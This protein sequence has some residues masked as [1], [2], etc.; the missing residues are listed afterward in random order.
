MDLPKLRYVAGVSWPRSGHH[1]L[2]ELLGRYFGSR[3][4]YC[5]FHQAED[6]CKEVPCVRRDRITLS[7]NHDLDLLTPIAPDVPYL[8][9][10]RDFLPSVVS[11]Y[12]LFKNWR[13][14]DSP[15]AFEH[16]AKWQT[17]R[18]VK[19]YVKWISAW[20][21]CRNKLVVKYENLM[22]KPAWT[23]ASVAEF[24]S[25]GEAVDRNR[26]WEICRTANKQEATENGARV[27][28]AF[29]VANERKLTNFRHYDEALFER[30]EQSVSTRLSLVM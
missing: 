9:Q 6:C 28:H 26:A 18:Y 8:I 25:P 7:K 10:Y 22:A 30:L 1:L 29:G 4:A 24:F 16:F 13:G 19:F 17:D 5:E 14:E 12:E 11:D 21:P 3:F 23:L 2:V 27:K 20:S 15:Q